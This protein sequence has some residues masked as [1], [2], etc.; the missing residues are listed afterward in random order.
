VIWQEDEKMESFKRRSTRALSVL[1]SAVVCMSTM[2]LGNYSTKAASV[3]ADLVTNGTFESGTADGWSDMWSCTLTPTTDQAHGG[4]Y[5]L[6]VTNRA[7]NWAG[8]QL[9]VLGKME[10]GHVYDVS[11]WI[12]AQSGSDTASLTMKRKDSE[13]SGENYDSIVYQQPISDSKWTNITGTYKLTD[14]N[15]LDELAFYVEATKQETNFYVDDISII[16]QNASPKS[17][18][19]DIPSL[20]DVIK[21]YSIGTCLQTDQIGTVDG[22]LIAKHFNSITPGNEFKPDTLY[23]AA[24]NFDFTRADQLVDFAIANGMKMRG[25]TFCWA[26]QTPDWFF[27]DPT[28]STKPATKDQLRA[29]LKKHITT[30]MQ[31]FKTKYGSNNPIYCWDVVNEP[32]TEDGRLKTSSDKNDSA[33]YNMWGAILGEEYIE[34]A[35]RYAR[36]ADPSMK[37][38]INDYNI[39]N[40]TAKTQ[41]MYD[42][43]KRLLEKGV[44]VDGIGIQMHI[45]ATSP[46]IENMKASIEKLGSLGL[47]I[48]ITELDMGIDSN[49]AA[50]RLLQ[51]RRYK[52]LFDLFEL[53]NKKGILQAVTIWGSADISSWRQTSFPLL[54]DNNY[55]AKPSFWAIAD[56]SKLTQLDTQVAKAYKGTPKLGGTLDS[57]WS[58]IKG[59][60]T[61]TYAK[62]VDGASASVKAMWDD[63]NL[64]L[65]ANVADSTS[66]KNDS[67]DFLVDTNGTVKTYHAART[68]SLSGTDFTHYVSSTGTGYT[69]QAAIPIASLKP[70]KGNGI[71]FDVRVNDDRGSGSVQSISVWNDYLLG[72]GVSNFGMLNLAG[73]PMT[74]DCIYGTPN[75]DG[76]VDDAWANAK[77]ITT[78]T[79]VTGSSGATANVK[80]M[81]DEKNLYILAT[82]NDLVLSDKSAN[83]WEQDS[84][85]IFVDQNNHKTSSYETDDGQYRV[86]FKNLQSFGSSTPQAGFQSAATLVSGGYLVEMAIPWTE[87]NP[88]AGSLIGFDAQVNDGDESGTRTG[89]VTWCDPSGSS[90]MDTSGFGNLILVKEEESPSSGSGSSSSSSSGSSSGSDSSSGSSSNSSSAASSGSS[91]S[92]S[93]PKTGDTSDMFP[94]L[95]CLIISGSACAALVIVRKAKKKAC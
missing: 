49:T 16:D 68:D 42:L 51:A 63:E 94:F 56:P 35:F 91:G 87:L 89:V 13:G 6:L 90:Y 3:T 59:L 29:L 9:D 73:E 5:S 75:V 28:D 92:Q 61:S 10:V 19:T 52:E 41:G 18:Q 53:E 81:W 22:D 71:G 78:G 84:V 15:A 14:A 4:S 58:I 17:I 64:Y 83:E 8:P 1:V 23:D 67:V 55:Q 48:Q 70:Q 11:V 26:N 54:F 65:L 60:S 76:K 7:G 45:T 31:H 27:Q 25:H 95:L 74:A 20:K 80:T 57:A 88:T 34:D 43:V 38:F 33:N 2:G 21:D 69:V 93:S 79:W 50:N 46:S 24:H 44:P 82:V 36:E 37:L 72:S 12:R 32:I 30:V 66:G 40:N 62:G 47:P 77:E 85:E 39:E 86:N